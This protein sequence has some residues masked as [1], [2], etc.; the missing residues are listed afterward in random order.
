[1]RAMIKTLV[2]AMAALLLAAPTAAK[3]PA[4]HTSGW[5]GAGV[6]SSAAYVTVHNGGRTADRLLGATSPAAASVSIHESSNVGGVARMRAAGALV[7]AP[8]AAIAM[9]PGGL[10]IML[11]GL[12]APLRPGSRLPLT[13]RFQKAGNVQVS[14][15][16]LAPGSIGP[17]DGHHGH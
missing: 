16:V 14:L 12:K 2:P 13:L 10:H 9:K 7:L 3:A 15:P 17:A 11:M 4:L 6:S 5:A 1:M 8:G